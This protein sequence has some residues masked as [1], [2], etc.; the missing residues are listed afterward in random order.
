MAKVVVIGANGFIGSHLVDALVLA[1]H[2][3]SAFDRYSTSRPT[4][5]AAGVR[6]IQGEFLSRAD[7]E[8]A[9][10]GQEYVFHFLSTTSPATAEADPTLDIRTNIAQ[11]V[12]LLESCVAAG[13]KRFYYAST[14]GA[15]YGP[16]NKAEY[17]E[18]DRALP[19][20]PYGIGKLSIEHYLHYFRTKHGLESTSLRISN[21]Y[22]T[23]QKPNKKQGLIPIALR[24]I[25][26]GRPVI[27]LGSGSMVRD[28][29]YVE[30][31][32]RMV[33]P[34][35]G[36]ETGHDLYNL[37]S[38]QGHSVSDIIESLRRVTGLDFDVIER[39][40][41][42]TFIDRVVLNIERYRSEFGP[43]DLTALDE[44]VRMTYQEIRGQSID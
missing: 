21:P 44:G 8:S 29:V 9:V 41:P 1:G 27:R 20:S 28:Y 6:V 32:V 33:I 26:L 37:G 15:I 14:G 35:V 17:S 22:G 12:E 4:F 36:V 13:V 16:Q 7:L 5:V 39:P 38:G 18:T 11:T 2:E 43:A 31:L 3:V 42:P 10:S 23:R 25:V 30:D 34:M 40:K 19:I 24:Q